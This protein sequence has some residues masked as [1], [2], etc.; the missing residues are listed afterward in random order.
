MIRPRE[1]PSSA[2]N[3]RRAETR[4]RD[5]TGRRVGRGDAIRE[6]RQSVPVL[7]RVA[8][9][10]GSAGKRRPLRGYRLSGTADAAARPP[11]QRR[12][13]SKSVGGKKER[14]SRG[15]FGV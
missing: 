13:Q 15:T 9:D 4:T 7:R 6:S 2:R 3:A 12:R 8:Q 1:V 5:D 11:T 14:G 10:S